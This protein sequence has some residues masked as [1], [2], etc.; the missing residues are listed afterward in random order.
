MKRCPTCNGCGWTSTLDV[1]SDCL[2]MGK[3][4]VTLPAL[5]SASTS[6]NVS[7]TIHATAVGYFSKIEEAK[8][9]KQEETITC[10]LCRTKLTTDLE[11]PYMLKIE[12]G[13]VWCF[14]ETICPNCW[15]KAE[16]ALKETI[17]GLI[18]AQR[19]SENQGRN[20]IL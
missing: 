2:G 14:V 11:R 16:N 6:A 8:S 20:I 3:L 17:D 10:F 4:I 9:A 15:P 12:V 1:C 5:N 13:R 18:R 7:D 19:A